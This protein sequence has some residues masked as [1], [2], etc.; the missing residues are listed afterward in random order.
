MTD[1]FLYHSNCPDLL[2]IRENFYQLLIIIRMLT[3][4]KFIFLTLYHLNSFFRSFSG[5]GLR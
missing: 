2:P 4:R 5:H 1:F 3:Y